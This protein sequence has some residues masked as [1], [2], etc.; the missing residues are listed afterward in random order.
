[1]KK[2]QQKKD[3]DHQTYDTKERHQR[4]MNAKNK[5]DEGD[6]LLHKSKD[7]YDETEKEKLNEKIVEKFRSAI[8]E[9]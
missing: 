8:S 7:I 1:M 6:N 9:M 3:K 2:T 5:V 4:I